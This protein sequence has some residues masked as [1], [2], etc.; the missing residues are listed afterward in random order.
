MHFFCKMHMDFSAYFADSPFHHKPSSTSFT[1]TEMSP[2]SMYTMLY[3]M[4]LKLHG[5]VHVFLVH[6]N[7][8]T[9]TMHHL[10]MALDHY[11]ILNKIG[12]QCVTVYTMWPVVTD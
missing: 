9:S 3:S 10:S 1:Y 7:R 12:R 8:T 4:Q 11:E 6:N 2:S 5:V